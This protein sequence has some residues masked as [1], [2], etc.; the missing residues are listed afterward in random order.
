MTRPS[1]T[2]D[3]PIDLR[4]MIEEARAA[5]WKKWAEEHFWPAVFKELSKKK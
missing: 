1:N 5:W 3:Q 2:Y 4:K